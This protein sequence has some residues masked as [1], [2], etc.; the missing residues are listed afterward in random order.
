MLK[1]LLQAP[2][3]LALLA[4][5][6]QAAA[7]D[8]TD[9]GYLPSESGCGPRA[10][11]V[12]SAFTSV[13]VCAPGS[14]TNCQT[15]DNILVDTRSWG[16]HLVSSV[17][18]PVLSLPQQF[19]ANGD[20]LVAVLLWVQLGTGEARRHANRGR[21]GEVPTSTC[22]HRRPI[23]YQLYQVYSD[24]ARVHHGFQYAN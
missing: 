19:D 20:P 21:T 9:I 7:T 10:A 11:F 13:T 24:V 2:L 12:N 15:I 1:R 17:L 6:L 5:P 3:T 22:I 16:L 14:S 18:S 4:V 8:Y 23:L